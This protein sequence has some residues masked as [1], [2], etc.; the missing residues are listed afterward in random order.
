MDLQSPPNGVW[1]AYWR[2]LESFPPLLIT[3]D[4]GHPDGVL[5]TRHRLWQEVLAGRVQEDTLRWLE[6]HLQWVIEAM[7]IPI[8]IVVSWASRHSGPTYPTR[9]LLKSYGIWDENIVRWKRD[10]IIPGHSRTYYRGTWAVQKVGVGCEHADDWKWSPG[11]WYFDSWPEWLQDYSGFPT[12]P[13]D[14]NLVEA[15]QGDE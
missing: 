12:L 5:E 6:P 11:I 8:E 13:G 3:F 10:E 14:P 7:T 2:P 9:E 15:V 4:C 1:E